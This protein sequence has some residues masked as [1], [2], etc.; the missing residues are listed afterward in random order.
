[1]GIRRTRRLDVER[2]LRSR[3]NLRYLAAV[4]ALRLLRNIGALATRVGAATHRR[5]G[6]PGN[7]DDGTAAAET[8]ANSFGRHLDE[9]DPL[10]VPTTSASVSAAPARRPFPR[11][12][13][14]TWK[15]KTGMPEDYARWSES[16]KARNADFEH[17]LW[18]D[19]DNRRFIAEY[20]PWFLA[21]YD[22]YPRE[23]YRA[24][25]VRYFFLY[26]FGG[27]YVDMDTECLK[28][29][30]PL[31]E[32]SADVWLGRMGDDAAFPHS[33]P[34]AV[35]ASRPRQEFWLLAIHLLLENAA[36]T[37]GSHARV[38]AGPEA[39]TGPLLLKKTYDTYVSGKRDAVCEMIRSVA[40]RLPDDLRP[41]P[42]VST[43]EL[44]EPDCW[45][46]INWASVI[47]GQLL[48]EMH[49]GTIRLGDRTK[50]WLFPRSWLVT[51]WGHSWKEPSA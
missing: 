28:P 34:N 17:F 20:Y 16:V 47:D 9:G 45:Y 36:T 31:F 14:Q 23:I 3:L 6:V 48:W 19:S 4:V 8:L 2:A 35:M 42:R 41:D 18:D 5:G 29:L 37:V 40:A 50:R 15:S 46:P 26:Q 22:A 1:M 32:S 25:A 33:I 27:V 44:R 43:V 49:D 51:Y 21:I 11:H 10:R 24:D 7:A 38:L 13:F 39:T 30:A 12:I